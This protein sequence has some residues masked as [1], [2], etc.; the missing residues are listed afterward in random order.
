M[1]YSLF[2]GPTSYLKGLEPTQLIIAKGKLVTNSF[3]GISA[4]AVI[5]LNGFD[6]D[7]LPPY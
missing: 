7:I 2:S 3:Q 5:D 6:G 4:I 1:V